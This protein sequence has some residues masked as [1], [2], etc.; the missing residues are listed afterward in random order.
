MSCL[1]KNDEAG[2]IH[3]KRNSPE[4][5]LHSSQILT[6][7]SPVK[8]GQIHLF[9]K[10]DY[11]LINSEV[12]SW[13]SLPKEEKLGSRFLFTSLHTEPSQPLCEL[14]NL[15][16]SLGSCPNKIPNFENFTTKTLISF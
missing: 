8:T 16:S 3:K 14:N 9:L 2:V 5:A 4:W 11:T 15:F 6:L 10:R 12:L 7:Q 1:F 13:P